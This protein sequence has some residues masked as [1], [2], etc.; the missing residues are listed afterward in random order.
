[1][2]ISS[3]LNKGITSI[4]LLFIAGA[5]L[6]AVISFA[7]LSGGAKY[8][9]GE[10]VKGQ[11]EVEAVEIRDTLI[12]MKAAPVGTNTCIPLIDCKKLIIRETNVEI[13]DTAQYSWFPPE[14]VSES[15]LGLG[16]KKCK[17]TVVD[18]YCADNDL[19]NIDNVN[20]YEVPCSLSVCFN[21]IS[22]DP[23]E[24]LIWEKPVNQ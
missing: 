8:L 14:T 15:I 20:G 13:V 19:E 16:L 6:A 2:A 7:T 4:T 18:G 22:E 17:V 11:A 3:V 23:P 1:M 12:L 21:K 10:A 9:I 24:V 5:I